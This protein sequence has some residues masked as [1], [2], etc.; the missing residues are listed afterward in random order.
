LAGQFFAFG[1][2]VKKNLSMAKQWY[3]KA[4]DNRSQKGCEAYARLNKQGVK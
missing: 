3:G 4:C 2:G 1:A